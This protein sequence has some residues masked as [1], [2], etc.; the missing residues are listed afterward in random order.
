[1]NDVRQLILGA[2]LDDWVS[3][4]E[5]QGDFQSELQLDPREA[6][7][8]MTEQVVDWI[9]RRVLVAGDML[10][11]FV[12]WSG[13]AE[14]TA[15]RFIAQAGQYE[16]LSRPGEICWFDTGPGASS[17]LAKYDTTRTETT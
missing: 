16:K 15:N 1:M 8:R 17:E 14:D 3:D 4:Y 13:S 2:V 7:Q 12:P 11:G 10:D 6:Y 9:R 5:I